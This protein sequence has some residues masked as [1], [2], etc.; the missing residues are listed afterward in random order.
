ME[1]IYQN[2]RQHVPS[3]IGSLLL[4]A[5]LAVLPQDKS[6]VV[7]TLSWFANLGEVVGDFEY[8]PR[9]GWTCTCGE[10]GLKE[11]RRGTAHEGHFHQ[12][13]QT[14]DPQVVSTY[15]QLFAKWQSKSRANRPRGQAISASSP[16]A[17]IHAAG[18]KTSRE[19]QDDLR[20]DLQRAAQKPSHGARQV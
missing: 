2:K 10:K 3:E 14:C 1:I 17:Q 4:T 19:L 8:P 11:S 18:L 16:D 12:G 9:I 15:Q 6:K 5:G 13:K 7:H 20:F